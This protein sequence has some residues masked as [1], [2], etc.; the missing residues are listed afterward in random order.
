MPGDFFE[1]RREW[2]ER[3]HALVKAY[4]ESFTKI[5]G[6]IG[7]TVYYV[8]GFAGQG[9]YEDGA[10]G[11]PVLIADYAQSLAG[12]PYRLNCINV[13]KEEDVFDDL[14][15]SM[16]PYC[17]LATNYQG[18]FA[19]HVQQV[20]AK[21]GSCPT[22]FFLDPCGLK[23]IEWTGIEPIF[24]RPH[25]TEVLLRLDLP[26][27]NRLTGFTTSKDAQGKRQLVTDIYGLSDP[28]L[29]EQAWAAGKGEALRLYMKRVGEAM[30]RPGGSAYV[31]CYSIRAVTGQFKYYLVFA[32]RH[33][34]GLTLMSDVVYGCESNFQR[35]VEEYQAELERWKSAGQLS[36]FDILDPSPTKEEI[37]T[38]VVNQLK[39]TI[40]KQF[41]G[42]QAQRG[43]IRASM[44]LNGWFGKARKAH[45]TRAFKELGREGRITDHIGNYSEEEAIFTFAQSH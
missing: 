39:E 23:G 37:F 14:E 4:V 30:C 24:H 41:A 15:R 3:K 38:V 27:M 9:F 17:G 33:I 21:I 13:E 25:V 16:Q 1:E 26:Y 6:S 18:P 7:E 42:K 31:C 44:I 12:K 20:L 10:K 36:M 8:D 5:L 2:S 22:I 43:H 19:D 35:D 29:W 32:T 11:S 28:S 34:K 45:Y 40:W